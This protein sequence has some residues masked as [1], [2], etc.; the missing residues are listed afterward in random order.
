MVLLGVEGKARLKVWLAGVDASS[1]EPDTGGRFIQAQIP[2]SC[3]Q[4]MLCVDFIERV[5]LES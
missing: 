2:T 1:K 4:T 5:T 3:I